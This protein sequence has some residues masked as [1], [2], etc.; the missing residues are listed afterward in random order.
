MITK[1]PVQLLFVMSV[2]FAGCTN[3]HRSNV[4]IAPP[5][6]GSERL[7]SKEV[8]LSPKQPHDLITL[9]AVADDLTTTIRTYS[10][11]E[12]SGKP[13]D[14]LSPGIHLIS[15]SH[16]TGEAVFKLMWSESK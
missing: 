1:N 12:L 8:H 16:Q 2:L 10:G 3:S 14:D 5:A 13:G 9:V 7:L 4:V 15:A 11:E 6:I